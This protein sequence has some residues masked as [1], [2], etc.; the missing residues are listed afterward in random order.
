MIA[1]P[2]GDSSEILDKLTSA[3][4][5]ATKLILV[6]LFSFSSVTLDPICAILFF[7][8]LFFVLII[9]DFLYVSSMVL[10]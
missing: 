1:F 3:S 6:L 9:A 7:L 10:I 5:E 4:G 8:P 2:N